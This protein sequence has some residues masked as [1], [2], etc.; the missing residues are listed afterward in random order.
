MPSSAPSGLAALHQRVAA[1][2]GTRFGV[3]PTS[4]V[5]AP[6]RVNLIGEHTDYNDG[7]VLPAAIDRHVVMAARPRSDRRV[8]IQALDLNDEAV[9]DLDA[10]QP[11][12]NHSWNNYQRGVAWAL[13]DAGY[14][15]TG[16]DAV[17]SSDVPVGAGLSSSAAVEIAC[18][19]VFQT[20]GDLEL[21]GV[22]RALLCQKAE[23]AFVGM[24]CGIMDQYIISLGKRDHALL[25]DCPQPRLFAGGHPQGIPLAD[26]QHQQATRPG[27]FRVQHAP[28]RVRE[29][30]RHPGRTRPARRHAGAAR[31]RQGHAPAP[32]LPALSA[33]RHRE[34]TG[35]AGRR[36]PR[37]ARHRP[38]RRVDERLPR[39][40]ARRL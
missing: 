29:W 20:L 7:F 26:L 31:G 38:F 17:M 28:A 39:Q 34:R 16:F 18:A 6:G 23:N 10:V 5:A 14:A 3:A 11:S 37:A 9:F 25:I 4:I 32:H 36:G 19:F 35:D 13:Q 8:C 15:L 2:F 21:D 22:K 1:A 24:R 12:E 27:R 40:S 30:R 33:H